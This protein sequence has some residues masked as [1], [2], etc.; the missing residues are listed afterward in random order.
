MPV[1][2]DAVTA[3]PVVPGGT[4]GDRWGKASEGRWNLA[5]GD[6]DPCLTLHGRPGTPGYPEFDRA[7]EALR[8]SPDRFLRIQVT[9]GEMHDLVVA[10]GV[11]PDRVFRIPIGIDL[12]HFAPV[13]PELRRA[14]RSELG[15]S[16]DAF[17]VGSFQK[18]GVGWGEGLDPKLMVD[19]I[20]NA[21]GN[22]VALQYMGP[23][24]LARDFDGIRLDITYKDIQHQVDL[25][26]SLGVPMFMANIG[27]QVYEMA[28]CMGHGS[29]DGV[30]V[31]KVYEQMAGVT[32]QP[33]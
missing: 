24:W 23:R 33:N 8:A 5:L 25:G 10:A 4:L 11:D 14:A 19:L 29:E 27:Q 18:D 12:E 3:E 16:A 28:R 6:I 15:V 26:K 20:S 21:T 17:V 7:F 9:H 2:L 32:S 30:A 1:L 22:S 31:I 13:G